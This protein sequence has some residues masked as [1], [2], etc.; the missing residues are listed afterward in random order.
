MGKI[1]VFDKLDKKGMKLEDWLW[2]REE[3]AKLE[4][5][6]TESKAFGEVSLALYDREKN[7]LYYLDTKFTR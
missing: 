4:I 1:K 6:H 3:G 5:V 2:E 7:E